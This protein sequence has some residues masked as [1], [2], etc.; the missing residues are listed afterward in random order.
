MLLFSQEMSLSTVPLPSAHTLSFLYLRK[1]K[2]K[3]KNFTLPYDTVLQ[4]SS[5]SNSSELEKKLQN[6]LSRPHPSMDARQKHLIG[7]SQ[8]PANP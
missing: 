2:G 3:V 6:F 1:F 4:V 7:L 8:L 5:A